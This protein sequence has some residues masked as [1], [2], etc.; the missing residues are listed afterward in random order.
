VCFCST[1]SA[2]CVTFPA[3]IL[4]LGLQLCQAL[5]AEE[6]RPVTVPDAIRMTR[7]GEP[8]PAGYTGVGPKSG[9]AIFSPDGKQFALVL[10]KGNLE[11]NTNDYSLLLFRTGELSRN[12]TPKILTMF[13]S[14][15]NQEGIFDLSWVGSD[16]ILFLGARGTKPVQL[17]SIRCSSRELKQLTRHETSLKS[18]AA[19][20]SGTLVYTAEK[21]TESLVNGKVLRYG[22][23]VGSEVPWDLVRGRV[24]SREPE[25]FVRRNHSGSEVRLETRGPFH[26]GFNDLVLSSDGRY[27]V[28]K[29]DIRELND[30]W[31]QYNDEYLQIAL[32]RKHPKGSPT[33][34]LQYELL[35]TRTGRSEVLLDSPAPFLSSDVLWSPD[36]RSVLLCG[37][38]LPLDVDDPTELQVRRSTKFVV[39]I[40]VRSR[41]FV[42]VS[43][44]D[45]RPVHWDPKT[46]I[47]QFQERQDE[48]EPDSF[49]RAINYRKMDGGWEKLPNMSSTVKDNLPDIRVDQDL[50]V[51]PRIVA[52]NGRT[53]E[54]TTI[55]DLNPQFA[56][57]R[58]GRVEEIHWTDKTGN[59]ITGG[60]YFPPN[61]EPRRRYPLVIQTHG[62]HPHEFWLDG[63]FPT[64]S[65]AQPLAGRGI[66]VLQINDAFY[67]SENTPAETERVLN[68]YESAI[69]YLDE[70]EIV[71]RNRV[72]IVGFSR[73]CLYVKYALTHSGRRFAAAIASDGIDAGY[74]QYA[75]AGP[76]VESE[77]EAIIG[78]PAVGPGLPV[79]LKNSP[80]FSLDRVTAPLLI[81]AIEPGSV[82]AEWEWFSGLKRLNK[83]VEL[84]YLPTG[85]HILTKPWDRLVS[86]QGSVDW[87]C[88]WLKAEED[89]NP[90]KNEQYARWR[91]LRSQ[92]AALKLVQ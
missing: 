45:L 36:S 23:V 83:P 39:E 71:D 48:N 27:L 87:F 30:K 88:F 76:L 78:A 19:S 74:F 86:Q 4:L 57:L 25:L 26:S 54:R 31:R 13:S 43:T 59:P 46:D 66:V 82:L 91:E 17:Y 51:P 69:D 52:V 29:T 3:P 85:V 11:T 44:G 50:N 40:N 20:A 62:F 34:L 10:R 33:F 7:M 56:G 84:L 24:A 60:L 64:A 18:Y 61:Y 9:F 15:S 21:R 42:K 90:R 72:G 67:D 6:K 37:G 2:V 75:L 79:W 65:A 73:T 41:A 8:L 35:D 38:Y 77:F 68:A 16:T 89:G 49:A 92:L 63:P 81:Q 80:G 28:L 47:V 70:R 5:A 58:F 55:L 14:A 1:K 32:R 12:R 22:F 53:G